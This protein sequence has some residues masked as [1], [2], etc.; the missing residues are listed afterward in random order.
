MHYHIGMVFMVAFINVCGMQRGHFTWVDVCISAFVCM[1]SQR[2][3]S[4]HSLKKAKTP[5]CTASDVTRGKIKRFRG[6]RLIHHHFQ[7]GNP[8]MGASSESNPT[9]VLSYLWVILDDAHQRSGHPNSR[10]RP[11]RVIVPS[12]HPQRP[13]ARAPSFRVRRA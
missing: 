8:G 10:Q 5:P 6:P 2:N 7:E 1:H 4:S 3:V 9:L 11:S 13:R 12:Q